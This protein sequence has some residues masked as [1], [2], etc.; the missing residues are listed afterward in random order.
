MA[1]ASAAN[2]SSMDG[3]PKRMDAHLHPDR[4][5]VDVAPEDLADAD[6]GRPGRHVPETDQPQ[7]DH[8]GRVVDRS[9]ANLEDPVLRC[10][11]RDAPLLW[12][13]I[14]SRSSS[15]GPANVSSTSSS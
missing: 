6:L 12:Y 4:F 2:S 11:E 9:T 13:G 14:Q 8:V 3:S 15:D 7:G 10:V 1:T 5:G